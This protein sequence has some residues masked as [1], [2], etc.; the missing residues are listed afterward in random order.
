MSP[1]LRRIAIHRAW[2]ET[3][4][5]TTELPAAKQNSMVFSIQLFSQ[6]IKQSHSQKRAVGKSARQSGERVWFGRWSPLAFPEK[7]LFCAGFGQEMTQW[8]CVG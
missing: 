7:H 5:V 4:I 8:R 3:T 6:K 1:P 2:G